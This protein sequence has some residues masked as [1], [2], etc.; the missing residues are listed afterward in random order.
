MYCSQLT[1]ISLVMKKL[2][3]VLIST[4][5]FIRSL[6]YTGCSEAFW[7]YSRAD[8]MGLAKLV[9]WPS[10]QGCYLLTRFTLWISTAAKVNFVFSSFVIC[11]KLV[12][13]SNVPG[14]KLAHTN[15]H[16][17]QIQKWAVLFKIA[18]LK[19]Y[20]WSSAGLS[21]VQ[22]TLDGLNR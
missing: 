4:L 15:F 21:Q 20:N 3:Q 19:V 7:A 22:L 16:R 18:W 12:V 13:L 6:Y 9:S 2:N 5:D 11:I 14:L 10:L 17:K 8:L 1:F